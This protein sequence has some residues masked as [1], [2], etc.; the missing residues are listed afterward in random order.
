M[1][2]YLLK[3]T[4]EKKACIVVENSD[5]MN[6]LESGNKS[7]KEKVDKLN[8]SLVKFTQSSNILKTMLSG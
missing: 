5:K 8:T 4:L 3:K 7:L 1:H 6:K 2:A